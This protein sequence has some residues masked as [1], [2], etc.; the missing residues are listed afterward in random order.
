[1]AAW[2]SPASSSST[3]V[4]GNDI[5]EP[6]RSPGPN[7]KS[8]LQERAQAIHLPQPHYVIVEETGPGHAKTFLVEARIGTAYKRQGIGPSKKSA[9]QDAARAILEEMDSTAEPPVGI[10]SLS[11]L[12]ESLDKHQT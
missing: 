9:A 11:E 6:D 2:R 3:N 10:A 12:S 1:M 4:L 8:T 5:D 7:Y